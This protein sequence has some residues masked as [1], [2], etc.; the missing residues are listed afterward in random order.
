MVDDIIE[1]QLAETF[2]FHSLQ[3]NC[4]CSRVNQHFESILLAPQSRLI[5]EDEESR[6]RSYF[7]DELEQHNLIAQREASAMLS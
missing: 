1:L 5:F 4:H 6:L 7:V 3:T 2:A